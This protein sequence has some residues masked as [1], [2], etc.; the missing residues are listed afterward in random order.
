[1]ARTLQELVCSLRPHKWHCRPNYEALH[2]MDGTGPRPFEMK[3]RRPHG[4]LFS[5]CTLTL[6]SVILFTFSDC[7]FTAYQRLDE[8][9]V[10]LA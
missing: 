3:K 5:L 8:L 10:I 7:K 2:I 1:M 4:S 6:K 9:N